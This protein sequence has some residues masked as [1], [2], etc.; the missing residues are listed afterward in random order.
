MNKTISINLGGQAFNIDDKAY[1]LLKE[2]LNAIEIQFS[3]IEERKEIINDVELR[4]A[5]LFTEKISVSK[6]VITI[7]DVDDI[8]TVMGK[9]EDFTQDS[10][11][12]STGKKKVYHVHI[13][14]RMYR[15]TDTRV[16]GG[17]CSGMGAYF[18]I[19]SL[20][21][22]FLFVFITIFFGSGIIIYLVLWIA[23][24]AALTTSQKLEMRG[25]A[26]TIEC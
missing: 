1:K 3:D 11:E 20:L 13:S 2:Y 9:P 26:V 17:V 8:M 6:E 14:K 18:N 23:I 12:T 5:E 7:S 19:D 4:L 22:R 16:L 24:P 10:G 21:F 25:E 15:D